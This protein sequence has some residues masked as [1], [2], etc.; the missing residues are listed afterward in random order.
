MTVEVEVEPQIAE[1]AVILNLELGRVTNS[2]RLKS[3]TEAITTEI[4]R[5]M[6]RIGVDL[7]DAKELR[8]CQT[9][10]AQLKAQ[11]KHYTVPSF[12][13]GGMYLVKLE[14]VEK[15]DEI[16]QK[17]KVDFVPIVQAFAEVVDQRKDEAK[18]R[19]KGGFN[20]AAYP[21]REQVMA[22]YTIEHRWLSMSTPTSLK[23]IS[24]A[25]FKQEQ[26][27]AQESLKLATDGIT[28][29]LAAEAKQLSEH[30]IE[31]LTPAED[32]KPKQ[33]RKS[34]VANISEFLGTFQLRNIG[35]S[36]ELNEQ[37]DTIQKLVSGLDVKDLRLNETL[38]DEVKAGFTK[39][40]A[41]L[42]RLIV[43][44]PSR[45]MAGEEAA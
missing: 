24:V 19:L 20:P 39:V 32:G 38:R 7:F 31:R 37:I 23:R 5:D 40:A 16:I 43:D 35:T 1:A 33:I 26:A 41:T 36:E 12:F 28:A 29:L 25:L 3:D 27:K 14:A 2:R 34:A 18:L 4:D 15:V 45:F 8:A 13:R 6:L 17:A 10:Q 42:D 22:I 11:I 9:F 44:K 30:L 21:T